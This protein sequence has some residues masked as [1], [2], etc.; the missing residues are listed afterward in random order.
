MIKSTIAPFPFHMTLFSFGWCSSHHI[1]NKFILKR[2]QSLCTLSRMWSL[3]ISH[4]TERKRK[5]H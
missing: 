4:F 1:S 3:L 5:R 2:Q